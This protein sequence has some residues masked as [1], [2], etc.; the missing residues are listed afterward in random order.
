MTESMINPMITTGGKP[1]YVADSHLFGAPRRRL[2]TCDLSEAQAFARTHGIPH[3]MYYTCGMLMT[4]E[5][6]TYTDWVWICD[7]KGTYCREMPVR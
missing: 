1:C 6:R 4:P 5:E 2:V 3:L 7:D